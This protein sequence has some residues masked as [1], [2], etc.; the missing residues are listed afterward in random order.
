MWPGTDTSQKGE[1]W[2]RPAGKSSRQALGCGV[3]VITVKPLSAC[4]FWLSSDFA[5]EFSGPSPRAHGIGAVGYYVTHIS[6][7]R[8]LDHRKF[9]RVS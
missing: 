3:C 4:A 5:H 9:A 8:K 6:Q 2:E 7:V 1:Q